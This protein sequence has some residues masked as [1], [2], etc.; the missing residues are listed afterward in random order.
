M[1]VA[2]VRPWVEVTTW[3]RNGLLDGA[4]GEDAVDED[5]DS[6]AIALV[7]PLPALELVEQAN[8]A[9]LELGALRPAAEEELAVETLSTGSSRSW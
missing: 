3:P 8:V 2:S 7:E 5:D 4:A 1:I 9:D 6:F